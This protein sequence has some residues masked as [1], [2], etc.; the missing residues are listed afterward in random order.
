MAVFS[1]VSFFFVLIIFS[2]AESA[3]C[4]VNGSCPVNT[5]CFAG[6]CICLDFDHEITGYED[7][8]GYIYLLIYS[9]IHPFVYIYF[10]Y[11]FIYSS[12]YSSI[13]YL[14]VYFFI[15]YTVG[16]KGILFLRSNNETYCF[17]LWLVHDFR[18][19]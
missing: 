9:S 1:L 18:A 17:F 2:P 12:I 6:L 5:A 19:G 7:C 11:L 4:P 15:M 13:Y 10:S 8:P 3:F 16:H 14:F